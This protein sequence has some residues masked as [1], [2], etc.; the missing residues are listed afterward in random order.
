MIVMLIY[1][2]EDD[3]NNLANIFTSEKYGERFNQF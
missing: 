2:R 3:K 1:L